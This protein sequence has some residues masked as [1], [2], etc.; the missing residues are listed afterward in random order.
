MC[1]KRIF[2]TNYTCIMNRIAVYTYNV[3]ILLLCFTVNNHNTLYCTCN[4]DKLQD[5]VSQSYF[6]RFHSVSN[7]FHKGICRA[8]KF[9]WRSRW[10][11]FIQIL[12]SNFFPQPYN[13]TIS[14]VH[15]FEK[16]SCSE[17]FIAHHKRK[18][19]AE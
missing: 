19:L 10:L 2:S 3:L 5:C 8:L 15:K 12:I 13:G 9:E 14:F 1:H 17:K 6:F 11:S 7:N 18:C 16:L 4:P